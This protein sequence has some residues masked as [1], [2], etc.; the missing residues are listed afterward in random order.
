MVWIHQIPSPSTSLLG[1]PGPWLSNTTSSPCPSTLQAVVISYC[2]WVALFNS[3][4]IFITSF[5][6][7]TGIDFV[8]LDLD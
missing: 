1:F 7:N 4:N 8:Y 2:T 5:F 3:C 6:V